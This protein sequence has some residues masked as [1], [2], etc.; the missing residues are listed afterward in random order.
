MRLIRKRALGLHGPL[1]V[2]AFPWAFLPLSDGPSELLPR[3]Q[4]AGDAPDAM[5]ALDADPARR[6]H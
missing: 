6:M 3:W 2:W 4:A 1:L 5:V